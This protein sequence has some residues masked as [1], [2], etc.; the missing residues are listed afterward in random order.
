MRPIPGA[1]YEPFRDWL[2]NRYS[3]VSH[4]AD[5]APGT[6]TPAAG[7]IRRWELLV[8]GAI[9]LVGAG[10]RAGYLVELCHT[11]GFAT[12]V[13]DPGFHDY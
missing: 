10:L 7:P 9:L 5:T 1:E 11:P 8:L 4:M 2:R 6:S 3:K 13:I 12:P